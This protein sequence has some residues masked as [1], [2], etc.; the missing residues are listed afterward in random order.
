MTTTK[1]E[2]LPGTVQYAERDRGQ[3]PGSEKL[4]SSTAEA[5]CSRARFRLR[6]QFIALAV[7]AFI[8]SILLLGPAGLIP[9][10]VL[11]ALGVRDDDEESNGTVGLS[12]WNLAVAVA[13]A[14]GL[15]GL[16][17]WHLA[18]GTDDIFVAIASA[19]LALPIALRPVRVAAATR[20]AL[21]TLRSLV[22][23]VWGTVIFIYLYDD[24]GIWLFGLAA[25][26]VVV[27]V[28]LLATRLYDARRRGVLLGFARHPFRRDVRAHLLQGVNTWLACALLGGVLAAGATQ[29]ARVVLA[30]NGVQI[31]FLS[32]ACAMGLVLM[33]AL[34]LFPRRRVH[35]AT[36]LAV[37]LLS[38]FAVLQ[39]AGISATPAGATTVD[40]PLAGEW[41]VYNAGRSVLLSGHSPN[42]R[43]AV[44][45]VRLGGN[46][47][48]HTGGGSARLTD[49]AG[50]G[51]AVTAPASGRIVEVTDGYPDNQPGT[52][53]DYANHLVMD[54]GAGRYVSMAH[55]KQG[56]VTVRVGDVVRRGQPLAA[57]GNNG[58]SSE[59]HLHMQVQ[60]SPAPFDASRTYP[61][62]FRN[63]HITRGGMWPWGDR[64][65]LRTGDL[66]KSV[67][68]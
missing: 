16:W 1:S 35:L 34:A 50:F 14:A 58:H 65:E 6:R 19:V 13:M 33:A 43:N 37:A 45:F 60:D 62:L 66:V 29:E 25:V 11:L 8:A 63:V 12:P 2:P 38:G 20:G 59:P 17:L 15:G 42:E 64:G 41:F 3:P 7:L 44:D 54:I 18:A 5:P 55:L 51:M 31:A 68:K 30:L 57:V 56:S 46:G 39:L 53:G 32:V 28:V 40:S 4:H 61:M 49:Y 47:R 22:L 27:P 10:G 48:T 67:A 9:F 36:N 21:V 52:D 23:A 24:R 26:C